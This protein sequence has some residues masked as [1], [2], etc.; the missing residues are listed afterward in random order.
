V[1][2][3]I[4]LCHMKAFVGSL[5]TLLIG[6]LLIGQCHGFG[7]GSHFDLTRTVL[8]EVGFRETSIQIVQVEN[9][10]TDYYST[11]PTYGDKH[12]ATL[13]KLHFDNLFNDEQVRAYWAI[14]IRNLKSS[15]EKAA[16]DN[17]QMS[18]L[19]TLGMGLHAVQ[20]FYSHSNWAELHPP[21][22]NREFRADTFFAAMKSSATA[23]IKGIRTGKYPDDRAS[24]P[25]SFPIPVDA[26]LH[27]GYHTGLN[28]DSPLRPHWDEAF[29]FAY[30]GSHELVGAMEAWAERVRPGFW[31]SVR[32]Y[33]VEAG[34][35][36]KLKRDIFAAQNLSMWLEGK[37]QDGTWKGPG[38][39]SARRFAALSSKWV[40]RDSS[41]F[42]EAVREGKIQDELA[43]DLYSETVPPKIPA[44]EPFS[45][46][47]TAVLI[48][49]AYIAES[50]K[51]KLLKSPLSPLGGPDYYSRITA[52]GQ[53]FLGRT[54]Q[55]SRYEI[56]PWYEI[57]IVDRE[58]TEIPVSISVWD[59]DDIDSAKDEHIDINPAA[60]LFDLKMVFRASDSSLSG[61][62]NGIFNSIDRVF[63]SEGKEPEKRRATIRAF[64]ARRLIR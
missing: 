60:G 18:M 13:E 45:L 39:G 26:E 55:R 23:S 52:A 7:T 15:T 50:K 17:D 35:E 1:I 19:V 37:G 33:V 36:K 41:I 48:K 47:R 14:L 6:S 8:T 49:V 64:I 31:R 51:S 21:R 12:R 44:I 4:E 22:D 29:V 46:R 32:E 42:V 2:I 3:I 5:S 11:S 43:A 56:E 25:G 62:I 27:G 58:T 16:E 9:W 20:D 34:M 61:D 40:P 38:S 10:L 24:G 59:E 28:K 63:L 53:E 57:L 30:A 54:I